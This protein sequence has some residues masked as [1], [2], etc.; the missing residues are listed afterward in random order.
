MLQ[1][2]EH[3]VPLKHV[4][5]VL[6]DLNIRYAIGGSMASSIHGQ[7][8]YTQDADITVEPFAGKERLFALRFPSAEYYVDEGMIRDA[9]ARRA[10]FNILHLLTSFKI[11]LFVQKN[12]AFDREFL[13]RRIK[14]P[15][16]GESEGEF[17]LITAEDIILV[18]LEW[19]RHGGETS[20]R[21]W[22]D[23]LGVMKTQY[24]RLNNAY[25]DHWGVEIGVKDLL[26]RIRLQAGS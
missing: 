13:A 15:V 22:N 23:I 5:R 9:I 16:F 11:D 19:Y 3:I 24:D 26:D 25:L 1:P 2:A 14:A 18:K 4:L 20:D 7:A 17:G 8:R 21:Q 6:D 12:R 10:S